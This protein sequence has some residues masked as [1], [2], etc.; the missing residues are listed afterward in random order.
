MKHRLGDFVTIRNTPNTLLRYGIHAGQTVMIVQ[1]YPLLAECEDEHVFRLE[2]R[3]IIP[4][5]P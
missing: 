4:V 1:E 2:P 5:N 3:D